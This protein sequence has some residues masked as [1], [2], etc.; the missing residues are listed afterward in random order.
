[1]RCSRRIGLIIG[2][3][4]RSPGNFFGIDECPE[5]FR[6]RVFRNG[7]EKLLYGASKEGGSLRMRK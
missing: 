2:S 1:M 5:R 6:A 4:S 3:R 7:G